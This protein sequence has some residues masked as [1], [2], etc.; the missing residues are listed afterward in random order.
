MTG[1]KVTLVFNDPRGAVG[2]ADP[3]VNKLDLELTEPKPSK[4]GY[5][6]NDF[7]NDVCVRRDL[8]AARLRRPPDPDDLKNNVRQVAVEPLLVPEASRSGR[9]AIIVRAHKVDQ[10]NTPASPFPLPF[11]RR[12]QGYALV[13][14]ITLS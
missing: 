1:I 10:L 5:F 9:W 2:A 12:S 7:F 8:T 14:C 13:A 4:F 3:V 6:G 11:V